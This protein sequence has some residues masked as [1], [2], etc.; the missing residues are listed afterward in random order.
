MKAPESMNEPSLHIVA[1]HYVRDLP[2]TR[3]PRIKG[4]MLDEFRRQVAWFASNHETVA[5]DAALEFVE[6][7]YQPA[8][9]LCLFTFDD[10]LKEHY[11][12]VLPVLKEYNIQGL[13]GIVTSCVE[14]HAVAP[15]HMNHFLMAELEFS[16][17]Q[18]QFLERLREVAP[19]ALAEAALDP[20]VARASYPLDAPEVA[21]FKFLFNF[22]LDATVRDDVVRALF[23][24]YLGNEESFARE[25]YMN[26]DEARELQR[27]G[28]LVAGHTHRH[29][30][31]SALTPE[32]LYE[33]LS[34][35]RNLLD[36]NLEPQH[37]WPFSY[38]YGKRNSYSPESIALLR[39]LGFN[40]GLTTEPGGN[41]PGTPPFELHRMDC[42]GAM[43]ALQNSILR[44]AF[45]SPM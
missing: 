36:A 1:Y 6:G 40:C 33:D 4:L 12:E 25:L 9:D 30:P 31:L 24:K 15:V 20:A 13:F 28:M 29:R 21:D 34:T 43:E 19:E 7:K 38:P 5:L 45:G 32:E 22:L 35:S 27:A 10:G 42:K 11:S 39:E 41:A 26:W 3:F 23:R 17:Y 14:D 2:R 44:A 18:A 8:N 16:A 37:L